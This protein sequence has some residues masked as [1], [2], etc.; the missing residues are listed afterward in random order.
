MTEV[1][2]S[3]EAPPAIPLRTWQIA[4]VIGIGSFMVMLDTTVANLALE[5]IR[6][7]FQSDLATIQWTIT[8]YLIA[9]AVSLPTSGWMC[10][11]FGSGRV[12]AAALLVF[13][14]SSAFCALAPGPVELVLGRLLKGL[15][16]G[17]LV[18]A[19]QAIIGATAHPRQLGRVVGTLGFAIALGPALGPA[20]GG[21]VLEVASWRWLFWFNVPV[22]MVALV[23]ARG[24]IP[25]GQ[26][27]P[28]RP[29]DF[30]GLFLLGL[31]LPLLLFGAAETG[32]AGLS[33][34]SVLA[35][36][37]GAVLVAAFA[38]SSSRVA[39][40]LL[41]LGLLRR[42]GFL[43]GTLT[44]GLTGASMYGGLLLI[45]LWFQLVLDL[46]TTA[47]GTMLL[48]MGLGTAVAL[49]LAGA[50]TDRYGPGN[51]SLL[52]AL[53]V[54]ASVVPFVLPMELSWVLLAGLMVLRGFGLAWAQMPAMTA[55]YN[56]VNAEQMGDAAAM[57]NI[58]QRIGGALGAV[59]VVIVLN[60]GGAESYGQAFL[61]LVILG[62][63][64]VASSAFLRHVRRR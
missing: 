42:G 38:L 26:Q 13:V 4:A 20:V 48:L 36:I 41:D 9:L 52:G 56:A 23:I 58:S 57:V 14:G 37:L 39:H 24:L 31:G 25:P 18:P 46:S 27:Q 44:A 40:P 30:R 33:K 8:A 53:A 64:T 6:A 61:L 15:S 21:A 34:T 32:S 1:S 47:T 55:A 35:M 63:L 2:T 12:W 10:R 16:G 19:G 54:L 3:S 62:V 11:R 60:G 5:S 51:I 17:L 59:L 43:A 28:E 29:L 7:D 22:G 49:P 45:P 50:L